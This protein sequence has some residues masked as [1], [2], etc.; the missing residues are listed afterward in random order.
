MVDLLLIFAFIF[1]VIVGLK[2]PVVAWAGYMWADMLSP[3][4]IGYGLITEFSLSRDLAIVCIIS[5]LINYKKLAKPNTWL[6][7]ILIV[8]FTIWVAMTTTWA[9][10]P[11]TAT[12]QW[13]YVNKSLIFYILPFFIFHEK[14]HI[15]FIMFFVAACICYYAVSVGIKTVIGGGGYGKAM[16]HGGVNQGLT[17]SSTLSGMCAVCIAFLIYLKAHTEILEKFKGYGFIWYGAMLLVFAGN[18]GTHSRTGLVVIAT[19]VMMGLLF[20]K[21]KGLVIV[22]AL[23]FVMLG[24]FVADELWIERMLTIKGADEDSSAVGRLVVWQWT[25]DYAKQNPFG[26]GFDAYLDN[27][28]QLSQYSDFTA[29]KLD[30]SAKAFHNVF[31]EVLGEHGYIGL[32]L[33][34]SIIAA[35]LLK[36]R[37]IR[38]KFAKG[39]ADTRWLFD[40]AT[41]SIIGYVCLLV[42]GMFVGI[43]YKP[44]FFFFPLIAL[45]LERE[46]IK[47][48]QGQGQGQG[49]P[50][51]HA[52]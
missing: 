27:A 13:G 33:Y 50:H 11:I 7:T 49:M 23:A 47:Q 4:R 48:G 36:F 30:N 52:K 25:W 8:L 34:L 6:I 42:T 38:S 32:G 15:E 12:R 1:F 14:R 24:Y 3:H 37:S 20:T 39:A 46:A 31:F 41:L 19:F 40:C 51:L 17:E 43:A 5:M 9:H 45:A 16:I 2:E 18:V 10:H 26:G 29:G 44:Y 28:G 21:Q 22:V 35:T